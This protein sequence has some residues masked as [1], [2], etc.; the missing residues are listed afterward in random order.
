M[1][2]LCDSIRS[3]SRASTSGQMVLSVKL[4]MSGTGTCTDSS[5]VL[6]AGGATM[7][8]GDCP[9]RNLASSSGGRTV[10][11]SPMRCAR[12][13]LNRSSSRSGDSAR[14]APRLVAAMA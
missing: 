9:D 13:R 6:A 1:V 10:A 14:C 8:V 7:V 11:D 2:E 12:R 3:T 5:T 4:A